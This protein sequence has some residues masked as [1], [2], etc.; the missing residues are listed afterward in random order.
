M[1]GLSNDGGG[2]HSEADSD[3]MSLRAGMPELL[4][5][6]NLS[7]A[8]LSSRNLNQHFWWWLEA[9]SSTGQIHQSG[10]AVN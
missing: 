8:S 4:K 6:Q 7:L 3:E 1:I 2:V 9:W 5:Q 10:A